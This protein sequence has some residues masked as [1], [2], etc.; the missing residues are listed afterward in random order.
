MMQTTENK[1]RGRLKLMLEVLGVLLALGG[2]AIAARGR[3]RRM[4][5]PTVG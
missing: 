1:R 4:L 3:L 5:A 2:G